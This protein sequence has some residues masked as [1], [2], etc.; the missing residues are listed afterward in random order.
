MNFMN[1]TGLSMNPLLRAGDELQLMPCEKSD[2]RK[3]DVIVYSHPETGKDIVHR[4]IRIVS[5]GVHTQGDNCRTEDYCVVPFG[6]V[7]GKVVARKRR[8]R[9]IPLWGGAKGDALGR[10]LRWRCACYCEAV[11]QLRPLYRWVA[12]SGVCQT[13]RRHRIHPRVVAFQ[14][15]NGTEMQAHLGG[16]VVARKLPDSRI[17][18]IYPPFRFLVDE[19]MLAGYECSDHRCPNSDS[20]GE[21]NCGRG[22]SD[23]SGL[24]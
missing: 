20:S 16:R 15:A 10:L 3:G 18:R 12:D 14:K 4:V 2:L 9:I 6:N 23:K 11:K 1:Y 24:R 8:N 5:Q 17:W 13:L 7:R 19:H 21:S 22:S